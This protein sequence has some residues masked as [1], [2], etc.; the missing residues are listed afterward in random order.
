MKEEEVAGR[1]REEVLWVSGRSRKRWRRCWRKRKRETG[2]GSGG[3]KLAPVGNATFGEREEGG[4]GVNGAK[5]TRGWAVGWRRHHV[6]RKLFLFCFYRLEEAA[7][8]EGREEVA[9][10]NV[11]QGRRPGGGLP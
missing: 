10:K 5:G 8:R 7:G 4:G 6:D 2:G 9:I 11:V 3:W 1:R